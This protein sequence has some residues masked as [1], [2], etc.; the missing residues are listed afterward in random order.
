MANEVE[1]SIGAD[2]SGAVKGIQQVQTGF[3]KM[4]A[5]FERHRKKI[6]VGLTALGG[7]FTTLSAVSLKATQVKRTL[8][9]K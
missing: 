3:G 9:R 2:S 7:A 8:L 5:A 4:G 6:G 1:I